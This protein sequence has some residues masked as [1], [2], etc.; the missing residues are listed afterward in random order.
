MSKAGL[1]SVRNVE[2]NYMRP[3]VMGGGAPMMK[4]DRKTI[5]VTCNCGHAWTAT[6]DRVPGQAGKF[7]EFIDG[8]SIVCP[9]CGQADQF[10]GQEAS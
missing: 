6:K 9:K 1:M 8:V 4:T 5:A 10:S 2:W 7:H 3:N